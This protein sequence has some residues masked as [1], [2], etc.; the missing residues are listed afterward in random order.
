MPLSWP[1]LAENTRV[2]LHRQKLERLLSIQAS[3][4]LFSMLRHKHGSP[5]QNA[6]HVETPEPRS[7]KLTAKPSGKFWIPIPMAKFL[8]IEKENSVSKNWTK[9]PECW[10][11]SDCHLWQRHLTSW[12]KY[13]S[14]YHQSLIIHSFITHKRS[15]LCPLF[16]FQF[17]ALYR[18]E[19]FKIRFPKRG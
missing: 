7:G 16:N 19:P 15:S 1:Y 2:N 4:G 17:M 6:F 13:R 12:G 10:L 18:E 5:H 3:K 14:A 8:R 11:N 9:Q